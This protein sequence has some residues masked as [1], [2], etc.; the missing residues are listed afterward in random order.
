MTDNL[1][2]FFGR[3]NKRN[4]VYWLNFYLRCYKE[5]KNR[6]ERVFAKESAIDR[7]LVITDNAFTRKQLKNMVDNHLDELIRMTA[8]QWAA[9]DR[10]YGEEYADDTERDNLEKL[11]NILD[12][13]LDALNDVHELAQPGEQS[14]GFF[15]R[16]EF[17]L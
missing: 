12:R 9:E 17:T 1:D 5:A 16:K 7:A 14:P 8:Q 3:T 15:S 13:T 6:V 2:D 11:L 10:L 4:A